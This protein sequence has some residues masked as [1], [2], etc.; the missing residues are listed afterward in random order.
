MGKISIKTMLC[1][2]VLVVAGMSSLAYAQ[3]LSKEEREEL[4]DFI[5]SRFIR[6]IDIAG[7]VT[8]WKTGEALKDASVFIRLTDEKGQRYKTIETEDGYFSL[9]YPRVLDIRITFMCSG[10]HQEQK[11][12]DTLLPVTGV[13]DDGIGIV[14]DKRMNVKLVP[15]GPTGEM[16][17][18][19]LPIKEIG[20]HET[21]VVCPLEIQDDGSYRLVHYYPGQGRK[22]PPWKDISELPPGTFYFRVARDEHGKVISGKKD[23]KG[24]ISKYGEPRDIKA[25]SYAAHV[26][27]GVTGEGNGLM[28]FDTL[29][30]EREITK[31]RAMSIMQ[32]APE[33]T[34]EIPVNYRRR[35]GFYFYVKLG[36]FYGK[37]CIGDPFPVHIYD[38]VW[39]SPDPEK[40]DLQQVNFLSLTVFM[41]PDGS[42][43]IATDE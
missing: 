16:R 27:L 38:D 4:R 21:E 32:G 7:V 3:K 2:L 14:G 35:H 8:D 10:Y 33:Y 12:G 26:Y 37:G 6:N 34:Q 41:Q 40:P 11:W 25:G 9:N 1:M 42:R 20:A 19:A 18:Y 39:P 13:S 24:Y 43:N 22:I 15:K 17:R 29:G 23:I 28:A 31:D 5:K 30:T 36:K